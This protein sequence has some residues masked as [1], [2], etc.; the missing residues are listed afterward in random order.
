VLLILVK[1]VSKDELNA[2]IPHLFAGI[3]D[4]NVDVRRAANEAVLPFMIHLGFEAMARH[5]SKLKV[6]KL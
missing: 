3:E 2:C 5:A 1:S 6:I 4:R